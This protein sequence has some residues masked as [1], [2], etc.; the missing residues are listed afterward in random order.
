MNDSFYMYVR[1]FSTYV[2]SELHPPFD[3]HIVYVNNNITL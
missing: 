1:L 3:W 2:A